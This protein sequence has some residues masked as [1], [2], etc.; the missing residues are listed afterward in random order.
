MWRLPSEQV[1]WFN[2]R[3]PWFSHLSED[4]ETHLCCGIVVFHLEPKELTAMELVGTREA[5]WFF[6]PIKYVESVGD[7]NWW[8]LSPGRSWQ[9]FHGILAWATKIW[10]LSTQHLS[11]P[12]YLFRFNSNILSLPAPFLCLLEVWGPEVTSFFYRAEAE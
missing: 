5:H 3:Q 9:K 12:A 11:L 8:S 10:S 7:A 6:L 4:E 1:I 2:D